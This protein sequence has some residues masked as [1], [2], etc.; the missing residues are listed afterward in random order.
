MQ[1][2]GSKNK[3]AKYILPV[4]LAKRKLNQWW[5][6]PFV[7]G[8]NIIDKVEGKRI[9]NDNHVY[10][11]A[12]LKALQRGWIPPTD[13]SKDLYYSV[14][15]FPEDYTDELVGFIGFLCSFGSKWWGGYAF[16]SKGQNYAESGSRALVKQA[17]RFEGIIF[18]CNNYLDMKIPENSI[19]YCDP[20]Y[21]NTTKYHSAFNHT[22]FWWW[23]RGK[24]KEG[25]TV[26][27]SEYTAPDDFRCIKEIVHKT[28]LDKNSQ[29]PRVEK[30]F[31]MLDDE[32]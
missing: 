15:N 6:E 17:S 18:Q 12:L 9:G 30:L 21:T 5:V 1:Y 28:I 26:F 29:Y 32:S 4:M 14:K 10:L 25:H 2:M 23:C 31:K 11:V 8:A 13:I 16:N 27:V 19:I 3:I 24:V 20:P 22:E 7:G